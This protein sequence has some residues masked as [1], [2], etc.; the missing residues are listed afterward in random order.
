MIDAFSFTPDRP[1]QN[2]SAPWEW[3]VVGPEGT[4]HP[5][6][7][8]FSSVGSLAEESI[9]DIWNGEKLVRLR[10]AIA[11]GYIDPLC[12]RACCSYVNST[13]KAFGLE[14]YDFRCT[15]NE[16][17][18]LTDKK[19]ERFCFKGWFPA[20][21]WG[22]WS[23]GS[24][25][26]LM[27]DVP[28]NVS[29]ACSLKFLCRGAAHET[30]PRR[31]VLVSV[32]GAAAVEWIFVYPHETETSVWRTIDVPTAAL[33]SNRRL[34]V[35]FSISE[36]VCPQSWGSEDGRMIGIGLSAFILEAVEDNHQSET[37]ENWRAILVAETEDI[38]R[39]AIGLA[40]AGN[41][42]AIRLCLDYLSYS[43]GGRGI[44]PLLK[45]P[46]NV[47][48]GPTQ[49]ILQAVRD[50]R[51]TPEDAEIIFSGMLERENIVD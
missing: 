23:E 24:E 51:L 10:G 30:S 45:A 44:P 28:P 32:N 13:K 12:R 5:C 46:N 50:G 8:A 49:V 43:T 3:L 9:E 7:F 42:D 19:D 4:T 21:S 26:L 47:L 16:T 41:V 25:A 48:R 2:C 1:I 27:I 22:V 34:E 40:K 37:H 39:T 38:M 15:P 14:S 11:E 31:R 29:S 20:E 17:F 35:K 36:P 6:C 33:R 18:F